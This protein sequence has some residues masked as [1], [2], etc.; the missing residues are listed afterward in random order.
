M[1]ISLLFITFTEYASDSFVT[2]VQLQRKHFY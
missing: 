1:L 2:Y